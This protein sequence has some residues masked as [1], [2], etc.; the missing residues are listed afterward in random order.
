VRGRPESADE[1][2]Q[3]GELVAE[4][5]EHETHEIFGV[6]A[7]LLRHSALLLDTVL[8][9]NDTSQTDDA[10]RDKQRCRDRCDAKVVTMY[11]DGR[12]EVA[13]GQ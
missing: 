11:G 12:Y 13:T 4:I 8:L 5:D 3:R 9:A 7:I 1:E 10:E 6:A 2:P